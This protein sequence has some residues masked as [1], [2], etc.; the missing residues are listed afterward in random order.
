MVSHTI[1]SFSA[2]VLITSIDCHLIATIL[3]SKMTL[4]KVNFEIESLT[5]RNFEP[6]VSQFAFFVFLSAVKMPFL[7]PPGTKIARL[8]R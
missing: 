1:R 4:K 7:S 6:E 3:V 8:S 2:N 5:N